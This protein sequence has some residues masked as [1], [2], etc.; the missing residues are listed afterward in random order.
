MFKWFRK[1]T[2]STETIDDQLNLLNEIGIKLKPSLN[3]DYLFEH[4]SREEMEE[5]PYIMLLVALGS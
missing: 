5:D 1:K 2:S 4:F 3:S